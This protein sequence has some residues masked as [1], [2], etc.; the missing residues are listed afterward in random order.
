MNPLLSPNIYKNIKLINSVTIQPCI[1]VIGKLNS[2]VFLK[3]THLLNFDETNGN[4][5]SDKKY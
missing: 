3:D 4:R 1:N 5:F 2:S